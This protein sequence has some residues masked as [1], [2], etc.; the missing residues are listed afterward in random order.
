MS[1]TNTDPDDTDYD[2]A[3]CYGKMKTSSP[4]TKNEND[5]STENTSSK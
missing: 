2:D 1:N 4:S 5:S 3:S